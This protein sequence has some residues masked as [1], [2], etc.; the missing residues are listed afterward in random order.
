MPIPPVPKVPVA[1]AD[2]DNII[3]L[4][5]SVDFFCEKAIFFLN[6]IDQQWDSMR[7]ACDQQN[8]VSYLLMY[9]NMFDIFL[10]HSPSLITIFLK[11]MFY[12][13]IHNFPSTFIQ[14]VDCMVFIFALYSYEPLIRSKS[15]N[16]DMR[17]ET[18]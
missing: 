1:V 17:S 7:I 15:Y 12:K 16:K 10:M 4:N 2:E 3:I 13:K 8:S 6:R 18:V 9:T 5:R 11:T 14:N